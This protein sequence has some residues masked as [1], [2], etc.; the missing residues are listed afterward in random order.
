MNRDLG[1]SKLLFTFFQTQRILSI[2][3]KLKFVW[4]HFG[5]QTVQNLSFSSIYKIKLFHSKYLV[6]AIF[7]QSVGL[8]QTI[9]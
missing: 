7:L 9:Y 3:H 1:Q 8:L 6:G 2:R 5:T 4:N